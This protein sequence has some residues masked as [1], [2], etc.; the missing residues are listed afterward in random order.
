M[1]NY[2][3]ASPAK[4]SDGRIFTDYRTATTREENNKYNNKIYRDDDYRVFLQ[5][6][7]EKIL[8][9]NWEEYKKNVGSKTIECVH[10][11]PTRVVPSSFR[12]ERVKYDTLFEK[13]RDFIY[14]C[15][16]MND[17]RLTQTKG[18]KY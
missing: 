11:Y 3:K 7:A 14:P 1:D 10:T 2:F 18:S 16:Q 12:E 4:M 17:Y 13:N 15:Q 9:S 6:N 5:K 8:D